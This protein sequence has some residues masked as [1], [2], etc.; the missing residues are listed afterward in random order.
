MCIPIT[1]DL[2]NLFSWILFR[3][4]LP[5]TWGLLFRFILSRNLFIF[6]SIYGFRQMIYQFKLSQSFHIKGTCNSLKTKKKKQPSNLG[7]QHGIRAFLFWKSDQN[8]NANFIG[9]AFIAADHLSL[10]LHSETSKLP[11]SFIQSLHS[12]HPITNFYS[13]CAKKV[14]GYYPADSFLL[15][16][17]LPRLRFTIMSEKSQIVLPII[18]TK[19]Q[20]F[21]I[22][23]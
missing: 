4:Q 16:K 2:S 14:T 15:T 7:L 20:I 22:L 18:I 1:V 3:F 13:D 8:Q 6:P 5:S 23:T 10:K 9:E 12:C 21:E 11:S 19:H 17:F